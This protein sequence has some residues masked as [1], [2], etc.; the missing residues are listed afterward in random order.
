[1]LSLG[2]TRVLTR[3]RHWRRSPSRYS[4]DRSRCALRCVAAGRL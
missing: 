1:M 4:P 2:R 3:R